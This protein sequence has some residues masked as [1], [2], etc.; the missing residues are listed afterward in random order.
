[1]VKCRIKLTQAEVNEL[2]SIV[3]RG[4]HTTQ[5]CKAADVLLNCDEGDYSFG[6]STNY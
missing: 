2:T 1:M 5:T 6:K 4:S 3:K